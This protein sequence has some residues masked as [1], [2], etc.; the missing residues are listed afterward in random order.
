MPTAACEACFDIKK[1][2]W[3]SCPTCNSVLCSDCFEDILRCEEM[4][5]WVD[6]RAV[7]SIA[8]LGCRFCKHG[9]FD[10]RLVRHLSAAGAES[11][12]EACRRY[13]A[14]MAQQDASEENRR[15]HAEFR[16]LRSNDS[17]LYFSAKAAIVDLVCL[18]KPCCGRQ[19]ADYDACCAVECAECRSHFCALFLQ[20][21]NGG[22]AHVLTCAQ[23][24][25]EMELESIFLP[26]EI[27]KK[28]MAQ[29]QHKK[30]A[31]WLGQTALPQAVKQRLVND[32]PKPE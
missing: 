22:H 30:C 8:K 7:V 25:A 27:W 32:F 15:N 1:G 5:G 9:N 28:H 21:T 26:L 23:R 31:D 20:R 29:M 4:R 3:E 2:N 16:S 19:F 6:P 12:Q 17:M 18:R 24:P 13:G 14:M 11:Y 10:A